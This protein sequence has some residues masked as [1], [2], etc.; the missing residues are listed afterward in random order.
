M[1]LLTIYTKCNKFNASIDKIPFSAFKVMFIIC[2]G[3]HNNLLTAGVYTI[4]ILFYFFVYNS[5]E[6]LFT[7]Y[8][9]IA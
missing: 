6:E 9:T 2:A 7:T 5:F 3:N 8:I 4:I 1:C